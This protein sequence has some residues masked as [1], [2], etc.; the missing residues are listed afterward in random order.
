M[1]KLRIK[2]KIV[3]ILVCLNHCTFNEEI[4]NQQLHDKVLACAAGFSD[5][6]QEDLHANSKISNLSGKI[7][8]DFKESSKGIIFFALPP[9]DRLKGYDEYIKCI[10]SKNF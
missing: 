1:V 7:S 5:E 9:K 2:L 6:V 3:C 8:S 4:A 10:E